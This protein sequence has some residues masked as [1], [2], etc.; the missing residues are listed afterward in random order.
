M[1]FIVEYTQH[2]MAT[3]Q[4]VL[5]DALLE[6]AD[7]VAKQQRINRSALIREALRTHLKRLRYRE[8]E[9]RERAAYEQTPD[10]LDEARRWERV[11]D[12]PDD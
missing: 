12:W 2:N 1:E 3:I 5:D 4:V 11:A 10:D 9:Q 7:T 8:M 6:L